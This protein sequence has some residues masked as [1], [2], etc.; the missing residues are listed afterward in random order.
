MASA[1][2]NYAQGV[3]PE[4]VYKKR[5]DADDPRF[6]E[7]LERIARDPDYK[8]FVVTN[9]TVTH[10]PYAKANVARFMREYPQASLG[11]G[12]A[13]IARYADLYRKNYFG[14]TWNHAETIE[15]LGVA[16]VLPTFA[17]VVELLYR[18]NINHLDRLFGEVIDRITLEGLLDESLLVFTADHGEVMYRESATFPWTHSMLLDHEVLGVPFIVHSPLL[19][20]KKE[21]YAEVTRSIDVFPTMLG[22][23]GIVLHQDSGVV[24]TDLTRA[25][26]DDEPSPIQSAFSHTTVLVESVFEQMYQDAHAHNWLEARRL[27]PDDSVEQIWVAVRVGDHWFKHRR[28]TN[29]DWVTQAFDLSVDPDANRDIFAPNNPQ[30]VAM[31]KAL[32]EYKMMLV[33]NYGQ[34]GRSE[35]GNQISR[36]QEGEL[37]RELG[38]IE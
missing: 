25:F 15:R 36:E 28:L 18:S 2:L 22:L 34:A 12:N 20:S 6:V 37:L 31:R 23:S 24:G 33:R 26:L 11:V 32:V 38:Y 14:L 16:S 29:G 19:E 17:S 4:N 13:E 8:A 10:G 9:F 21:R 5:L 3:K 1:K 27:F 7:V 30:H 35:S